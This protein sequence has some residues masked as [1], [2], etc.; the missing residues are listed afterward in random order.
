MYLLDFKQNGR[1]VKTG[2]KPEG[3]A[4]FMKLESTGLSVC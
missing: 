1:A 3:S 4:V 2:L